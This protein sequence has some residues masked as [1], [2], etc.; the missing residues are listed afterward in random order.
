MKY[1]FLFLLVL[2]SLLAIGCNQPGLWVEPTPLP[3]P[4]ELT[5]TPLPANS[6]AG[7]LEAVFVSRVS[8]AGSN[9]SRCYKLYRFYPDGLALYS[10]FTCLDGGLRGENWPELDSWFKR[11][12]PNIDRGDYSLSAS[13]IFVRIV[14]YN[15]VYETIELRNFQGEICQTKMV[16]QEPAVSGFS[17]IPSE[18]TQPVLEFV[19][20]AP[21]ELSDLTSQLPAGESSEEPSCHTAGFVIL[22]R[23]T[24]GIAG[25]QAE[26]QIQTDPGE[27]CSLRYSTPDGSASPAPGTGTITADSQG[28]CRWVWD[29]GDLAGEAQVNVGIDEIWQDFSL[30]VR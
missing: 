13:K 7:G 24:I 9:E 17:G 21:P 29:L 8:T 12:D 30:E 18:L 26:Y 25:N 1:Q 5:T 3:M 19:Q 23:Q 10:D 28:V 16:L 20:L 22:K 2:M 11:E 14:S 15:H 4:D 6:K 27:R